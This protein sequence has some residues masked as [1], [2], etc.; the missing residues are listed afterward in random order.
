LFIIYPNP[1]LS[2]VY[3]DNSIDKFESATVFNYL[4]QVVAEARFKNFESNQEVDLSSFSAGVYVVKF[5]N[6]DK[7]IT[8]KV[9]KQ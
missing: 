3:F 7:S 6:G 1:T 8:K 2:K 4:G 5:A 9:I